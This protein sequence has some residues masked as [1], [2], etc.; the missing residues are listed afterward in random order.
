MLPHKLSSKEWTWK[1]DAN[2]VIQ[3]PY[4][5]EIPT[6]ATRQKFC[7]TYDGNSTNGQRCHEASDCQRK[8]EETDVLAPCRGVYCAKIAR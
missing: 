3:V 1:H 4:H 2:E 5:E 7:R 6:G 8:Y